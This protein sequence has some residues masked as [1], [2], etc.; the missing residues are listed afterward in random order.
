ML[1]PAYS[2]MRTRNFRCRHSEF[3]VLVALIKD[4]RFAGVKIASRGRKGSSGSCYNRCRINNL[5]MRAV[6]AKIGHYC[7]GHSQGIKVKSFVPVSEWPPNGKPVNKQSD[8]K[9]H[10]IREDGNVVLA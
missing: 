9:G 8:E 7:H 3:G 1:T 2:N 6:N 10:L 5:G 4:V